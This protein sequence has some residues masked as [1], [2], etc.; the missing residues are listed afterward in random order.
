LSTRQVGAFIAW[1]FG[2]VYESRSGLTALLHRLGLEYHKPDVVARKLDVAKQKDFTESY[3]RLLNFLGD[4]EAVLFV[5]AV[6]PTHAGGPVGSWAPNRKSLRSSRR[7][8]AWGYKHRNVT[9][10][11]A[12]ETCAQF[13]DA[14]LNFL[15]EKVPRNWAEFCDSVTDNFRIINPKD[16]RMVT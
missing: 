12:Y 3:D 10:N 15:R 7:A 14:A 6:H 8:G 4:D 2:L 16:F 1:E 5:D 13:A 9:H 11:K